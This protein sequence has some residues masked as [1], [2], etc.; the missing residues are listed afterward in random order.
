MKVIPQSAEVYRAAVR[1]LNSTLKIRRS[2]LKRA[3]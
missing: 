2:A 1:K 3:R